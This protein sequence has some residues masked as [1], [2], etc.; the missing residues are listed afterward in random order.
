MLK[1]KKI[2]LAVC[3]SIAFYKAYEILSALKKE[4]ADVRVML[5]D[6]AL[7]F[8]SEAGFEALCEHKI[9]TSRTESWQDGLNHIAY[10][11][12]DLILIAP[13]S[14]NTINKYVSGICDNVFLQTLIASD[15][16]I[17]IAP[18]ANNKMLENPATQENIEILRKRGV[19]F[20]DPVEKILACGDVGKGALADVSTIIY[21]TKRMLTEPKFKGQKVIVTGGATSEKIDDV[22]AVTNLSSGKT[23]K[24]LADAFYYAGADVTLIAS[25]ETANAPYK[26]LKFQSSAQLKELLR[27]NLTDANLLTMA[28]AVSDYAP[29]T[30]F[31]GKLKKQNLG[32]I[33]TLELAQNDDILGSLADFKNVKKIGF[34]METDAANAMQ[35]AKNMLEKKS[36]DAVCLNVLGGDINFGSD[37]TQITFIT[38][39]DA[40]NIA[41]T[42]KEDAARQI[43]NLASKL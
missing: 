12:T 9:L 43:V 11:K 27:A 28:A 20:I 24:A 42:S 19:K 8:C 31:E 29:K 5:S 4:G 21:E 40:Q 1:N 35:N 10:A 33:W 41:L 17:L 37:N 22:R 39:H 15:A 14:V 26:T 30:K 13:A 7:K 34:K 36:L 23:A 32:E 18:A 38:R 3:G 6:G 2:L 16:S 25:F